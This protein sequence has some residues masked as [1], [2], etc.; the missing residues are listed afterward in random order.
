MTETNIP[1]MARALQR[2]K[3]Q[4]GLA[5]EGPDHQ[6]AEVQNEALQVGAGETN[7]VERKMKTKHTEKIYHMYRND[8]RYHQ[9]CSSL[10]L[11]ERM[12]AELTSE[13]NPFSYGIQEIT[14]APDPDT[15]CYVEI[16]RK[17]LKFA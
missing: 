2:K 14:M 10:E 4:D 9:D 8:G 15:G 6:F 3:V 17:T 5:H 11:A 1:N 7:E 12:V 16:G 13:S